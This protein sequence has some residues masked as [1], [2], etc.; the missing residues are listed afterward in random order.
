MLPQATE[1]AVAAKRFN[2]NQINLSIR[3]TGTNV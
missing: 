3:P 1:N 2:S